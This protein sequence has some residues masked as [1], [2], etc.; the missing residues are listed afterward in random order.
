M[1]Y[2]FFVVPVVIFFIAFTV[3]VSNIIRVVIKGH[4]A[5]KD[6]SNL[7]KEIGDKVEN[8]LRND[9]ETDKS[10]TEKTVAKE[11]KY[12]KNCGAKINN[13]THTCDYCGK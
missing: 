4:S 1:S 7:G 8:A 13:N 12:C 6:V 11:P 2:V 3:I 5:F 9:T 10:S